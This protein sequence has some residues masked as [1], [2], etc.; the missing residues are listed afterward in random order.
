M[1]GNVWEWCAD[2]YGAEYYKNSPAADPAGPA[3]GDFK[4]LRGGSWFH[5]ADVCRSARRGWAGPDTRTKYVGF[6]V[7]C[8]VKR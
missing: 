3:Q 7:A 8:D 1:H 4:V 2:W 6:R 5:T